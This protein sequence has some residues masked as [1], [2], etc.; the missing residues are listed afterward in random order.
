[1]E[2]RLAFVANDVDETIVELANY[3]AG[4]TENLLT[5]NIKKDNSDFLL[6]GDAGEAYI[7]TAISKK[8]IK[9]LAQ[10]WVKGVNIDWNLLYSDHKPD[11]VSLPV[12]PFARE[13]HWFN[14]NTNRSFSMKTEK[15]THL[16]K[17][18]HLLPPSQNSDQS[19]P[20]YTP[21]INLTIDPLSKQVFP[22]E[23]HK[24]ESLMNSNI[25][26]KTIAKPHTQEQV[27]L[28]LIDFIANVLYID[29]NS[30][31]PREKFIDLG[32]DSIIGV[33]LTKRIN[34]QFAIEIAATDLYNYPAPDL[35]AG[36]V[37]EQL[38]QAELPASGSEQSLPLSLKKEFSIPEKT[39]DFHINP[40]HITEKQSSLQK[41]IDKTAIA[42]IG[43]S[44]RFPEAATADVFW[45][46]LKSGKDLITQVPEARWKQSSYYDPDPKA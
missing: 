39:T 40:Q 24:Q 13:R 30:I 32:L 29:A 38:P 20:A 5:G 4:K 46:H 10:L 17:K 23:H 7:K 44:C 9:A 2:E 26:H 33:E 45:E 27:L 34:D 28:Q 36:F 16:N 1:M 43:R 6:E 3:L 41:E 31:D 35:L 19:R 14:E 25:E 42:V 37:Y 18:I 12:Y 15:T 8:Q 11:K 21:K 22:G